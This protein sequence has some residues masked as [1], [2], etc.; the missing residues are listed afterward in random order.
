MADVEHTCAVVDPFVR[1]ASDIGSLHANIVDALA[2]L[3]KA[4]QAYEHSPNSETQ[5]DVDLCDWRLDHLLARQTATV[6]AQV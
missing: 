6:K 3:R 5:R 1:P 2:E 4:R